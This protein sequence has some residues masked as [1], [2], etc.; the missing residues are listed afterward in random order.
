[1]NNHLEIYLFEKYPGLFSQ[2]D[3]AITETAMCWGIECGDGWFSIMDRLCRDIT[4]K[5]KAREFKC[6]FTQIKEKYGALTIYEQIENGDEFECS[7]V[8]DRIRSAEIESLYTCE[9]CG[10]SKGARLNTGP[11]YS[12]RCRHCSDPRID[13]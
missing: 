12:V 3:R 6:E 8:E 7:W 9:V 11:W 13:F 5:A 1:M 2:K 10:D 4:E